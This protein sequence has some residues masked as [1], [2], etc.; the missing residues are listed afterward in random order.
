MSALPA[1]T[2]PCLVAT[3]R[4]GPTGDSLE[5][6]LYGTVRAL[7]DG[8]GLGLDDIDHIAIASSDGLDGRAISSMVTGPAVGVYRHDTINSS[9]SG[10]HA[11]ILACLRIMAGRSRTVLTVNWGH[12]SEAPVDAVQRLEL[13]PFFHRGLGGNHTVFHGLQAS[14]YLGRTGLDPGV[15]DEVLRKNGVAAQ[16]GDEVVAW[17]LRAR[18]LPPQ[19]DGSVAV[20]VAS[21]AWAASRGLPAVHVTGIGWNTS[22]FWERGAALG[23][24]ESLAAAAAQAYGRAGLPDP[25]AVDFVETTDLTPFHEL[26]AYEALGLCGDGEAVDLLR[27]GATAPDGATPV[28][29]S[30]GLHAGVPPFAHGLDRVAVAAEAL[31]AGQGRRAL[32][33]AASGLAAQ[34]NSVFVLRSE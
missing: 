11:L 18:H 32:V 10:E 3:T 31:L 25:A 21:A 19:V 28:N 8:A 34:N 14:A 20:L 13:E 16:G 29:R 6:S 22:S 23:R 2:Q 7:L 26:M 12:P 1:D 9:S 24:L 5:E 27:S 30:G 15:A 17:P 4:R 33:H